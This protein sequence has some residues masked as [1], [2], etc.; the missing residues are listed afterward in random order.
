MSGNVW[1]WVQDWYDRD[2]YRTHA[3][4]N[5]IYEAGGSYRVNRG[6]SWDNDA[7]H[8]RCANR[9]YDSPGDRDHSLGFRL[10]RSS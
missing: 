9:S 1:E 2:A 5:P 10:L 4:K 6:G 7:R 8:A 3:P